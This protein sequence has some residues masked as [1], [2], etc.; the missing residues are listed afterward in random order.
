M[1]GWRRTRST[2]LPLRT[3]PRRATVLPTAALAACASLAAG[4]GAI[5]GATGGSGDGPITV[6]TWAPEQTGS[7]N[8]PGMPAFAK[9]YARW[10]NAHGGIKGHKLKVL[11]CNDHNDSVAAAKCATTAV[12][13]DVVAV[14]GSYSQYGDSYLPTLESAGIPY[15]GG[16]GV[17][18]AEFT[19]PLSYPVNGGQPSLLAGL[20]RELAAGCGP[21]ALIRPDSIAGDELPAM[22]DS[23]LKAGGHAPAVD[24]R[25]ADDTT[26]YSGPSRKALTASTAGP[27]KKGCV[28]P[29]LGDR[30]DT[31][32][33]SFRRDREDYPAVK[34]AATLDSV[35]QT[36][37]NESGGQSGPYE[38]SY[39]SGWYPVTGD[40]RWDPMKKV[41]Q[42]QAFGD[43]RIDPADAGVQTTW[44]AYT[45]FKAAVESLDDQDVTSET[46]RK[47]LDDGLRISTGGLT[48]TLSWATE[49][50][51]AAIGFPRLVNADLTLQ[52][53][54]QGRLVAA[55]KGFVN[56]TRTLEGADVN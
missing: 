44:I 29:A 46:V 28:I 6:M 18:T 54:R 3:R 9:A 7:T 47:A 41:I 14:V 39:V 12:K 16:Y 11:T 10:V 23:G 19:S 31:F 4:C 1:T 2:F 8:K 32:M 40:P 36:V 35:D 20:G 5:P 24:Q 53:V 22:L 33:D 50:R 15:I 17:T 49:S 55:D 25:A 43:N 26:E 56:V 34:T 21:V 30:T 42:E 37:I 13:N 38:G 52:M 51:L 27:P 48:P 45:V